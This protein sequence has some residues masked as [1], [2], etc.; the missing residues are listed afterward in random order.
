MVVIYLPHCPLQT[1]IPSKNSRSCYFTAF[2]VEKSVPPIPFTVSDSQALIQ[3]PGATPSQSF[4]PYCFSVQVQKK[5]LSTF[6]RELDY[7]S[8][9]L[10]NSRKMKL[11]QE[12][13]C[14]LSTKEQV[15]GPCPTI[16]QLTREKLIALLAFLADFNNT[17]DNSDVWEDEGV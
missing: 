16:R 12:A 5:I 8:H 6:P 14:I 13:R 4:G 7:W 11:L 9:C 2:F 1:N 17:F 10:L 3:D 15:M